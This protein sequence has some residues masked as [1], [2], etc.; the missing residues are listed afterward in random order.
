MFGGAGQL[1]RAHAIDLH[2]VGLQMLR[3]QLARLAF[4]DFFAVVQHQQARAQALGFVHEVG[5]QQ[6]RL[7]LLQQQLQPLPHQVPRLRVQP[8]RG[9][10][11]QQQARVVDERARQ[12][13]A[14]LHAARQ[15]TGLAAGLVRQRGKF[16][17]R[18]HAGAHLR[19]LHAEIAAIDLQVFRAAEIRVQRVELADHA[20]TGLDGQR[21]GGH[22]QTAILAVRKISDLAGVRRGQ[23]QAHADGG[24]F[25]GAVGADHAQAFAGRNLEGQVVHDHRAAVV[26]GQAPDLE[27]GR[28]H[29]AIVAD[30]RWAAVA[31]RDNG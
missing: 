6:N 11:E 30:L 9:F 23:A 7:A 25:S 1:Q 13:Q 15:F 16:Q 19:R 12:A 24:G 3:D 31:G 18:R 10:V 5:G 14:P 8:G 28:V 27:K 26:F 21:I 17:Q 4:G 2:H 22:A 20:E 29:A